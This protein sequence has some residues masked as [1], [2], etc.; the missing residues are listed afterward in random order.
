MNLNMLKTKIHRA[1]VTGAD[2]TYEGSISLSPDLIQAAGLLPFE[3]VD[4]YNCNNGARFHTYVI[5]GNPGEV[6]LNGAAAR[7]VA[8]GDIVIIAAYAS[9]EKEEAKTHQPTAVFVDSK[10]E[11]KRI[12]FYDTGTF[13]KA[14][15]AESL[16]FSQQ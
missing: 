2:L 3:Q 6:C 1:T 11:V 13:P 10:N 9:L 8:K 14:D 16:R 4:I 5:V 12:S 7:H 15:P